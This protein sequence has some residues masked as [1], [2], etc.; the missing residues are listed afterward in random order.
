[1]KIRKEAH[2]FMQNNLELSELEFSTLISALE[3]AQNCIFD[4]E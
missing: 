4:L 1:M 3:V 2:L